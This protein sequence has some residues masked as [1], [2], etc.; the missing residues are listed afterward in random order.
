MKRFKSSKWFLIITVAVVL[1]MFE[2]GIGRQGSVLSVGDDPSG[3]SYR[4]FVKIKWDAGQVN[5]Y[6]RGHEGSL[7]VKCV[8]PAEGENYYIAHLP[9]I[10]NHERL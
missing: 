6:R 10:G 3:S 8:T 4:S 2:G 7:D 1:L 5:D 9:K